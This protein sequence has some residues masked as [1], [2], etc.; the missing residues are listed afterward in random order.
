MKDTHTFFKLLAKSVFVV[1]TSGT[2]LCSGEE[3]HTFHM[4]LSLEGRGAAVSP[5]LETNHSIFDWFAPQTG[6]QSVLKGFRY[7]RRNA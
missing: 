7:A 6:L 1:L 4:R 5:I 3:P 2:E